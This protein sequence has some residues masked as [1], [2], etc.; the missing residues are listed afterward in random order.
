M[1]LKSELIPVLSRP[2]LVKGIY[3]LIFSFSKALA[4]TWKTGFMYL[5]GNVL[6]KKLSV[7]D[8]ARG[9]FLII[10]NTVCN[11][12]KV[13]RASFLELTPSG[14]CFRNIQKNDMK[15]PSENRKS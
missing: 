9:R 1:C 6:I 5:I 11:V 14:K 15:H 12:L 8:I 3:V 7:T 10:V 13:R 2:N 4:S